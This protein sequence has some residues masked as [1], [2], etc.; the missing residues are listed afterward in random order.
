MSEIIPV[1][2]MINEKQVS[3]NVETC[4]K[5][6]IKKIFIIN[7]VVTIE[8]LKRCAINVKNKHPNLWV[9]INMLGSPVQES[10]NLDINIDALWIDETIENDHSKQRQFKGMVFGGLAFKYQPQPKDLKESCLNVI[11]NT[12][13]A[14]TSGEGT[15]KAA[16]INKIKLIRSFLGNH[17][18]AIASGVS[19]ENIHLYKDI[20]DYLL[21]ASSITSKEEFIIEEKLLELMQSCS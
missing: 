1:I 3:Q 16:N 7:H 13:V 6:N 15:G 21:V 10:L 18:M 8:D 4:L 9:G 17:P 14:T 12:D 19:I 2:H 20:V 11:K 5:C